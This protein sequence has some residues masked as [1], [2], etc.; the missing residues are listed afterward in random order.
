MHERHPPEKG[1]CYNPANVTNPAKIGKYE[2]IEQI[3]LGGFSAVYKGRDPVIGRLVAIKLCLAEEKSFRDRFFRE[4]HIAGNLDHSSIVTVYDFGIEDDKPFLVQEYLSGQDLGELIDQAEPLPVYRR[5]DYLM[6]VAKG[7]QYAHAK[8]V[9]HRDI[10]PANVRVLEGDEIRIMDFGIAT[11][12]SAHTRL[13]SAGNVVGTAGYLAPEQISGGE[14]HE[15]A[16]IFSFGVLAYELMTYK[17]PFPGNNFQEIL[18]KILIKPPEP[19]L[20]VWPECPPKLATLIEGCLEKEPADRPA[21]FDD[22]LPPL[23]TVLVRTR[24]ER[25]ATAENPKPAAYQTVAVPAGQT[26]SVEAPRA[27]ESAPAPASSSVEPAAHAHPT[28]EREAGGSEAPAATAR[29][30]RPL[31][32]VGAVALV[33]AIGAI[34]F[35]MRRVAPDA[36]PHGEPTIAAT[37][38]TWQAEAIGPTPDGGSLGRLVIDALPWARITAITDSAG[39]EMPLPA[40]LETPVSI[41]LEPGIYRVLMT[42]PISDESLACEVVLAASQAQRCLVPFTA[43]T[44]TEYFRRLGWWQ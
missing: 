5:L 40:V 35:W 13:T 29:R 20:E 8:G 1:D 22:I 16:D 38:R 14:P 33:A 18:E 17:R 36:A 7:L 21:S 27:A 34:A 19:L 24:P 41:E 12:K 28:R 9:V 37:Y 32:V 26:P 44:P 30:W 4:A 25:R 11:L 15:A 10:K 2:V 42:N 43:I 3:G 6:K 39:T 31:V 23:G